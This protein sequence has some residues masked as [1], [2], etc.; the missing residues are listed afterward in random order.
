MQGLRMTAMRVESLQNWMP[1]DYEVIVEP[2]GGGMALVD[3]NLLDDDHTWRVHGFNASHQP[4]HQP[5][6]DRLRPDG[7]CSLTVRKS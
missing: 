2:T 3:V 6:V 1:E 5:M 4:N 7:R